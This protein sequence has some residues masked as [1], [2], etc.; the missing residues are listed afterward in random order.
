[1][2]TI[3]GEIHKVIYEIDAGGAE[4]KGQKGQESPAQ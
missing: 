1:M 2:A 4:P 3:L